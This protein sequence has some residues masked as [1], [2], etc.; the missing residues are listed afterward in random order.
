MPCK[1]CDNGDAQHGGYEDRADAVGETLY[2]RTRSLRF[3]QQ[4]D[5]LCQGAVRTEGR[6]MILEGS[7]LVES[8]A[9]NPVASGLFDRQG[10]AREHGFVH[11]ALSEDNLAVGRNAFSW[12]HQDEVVALN[13]L[14]RQIVFRAVPQN[15]CSL[16]LHLDEL[17]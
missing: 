4:P 3:A 16:R 14:Q 9:H 6:G 17:A 11:T 1:E 15:A 12:T 10:L 8:A 5:D 7:G 13:G 2:R